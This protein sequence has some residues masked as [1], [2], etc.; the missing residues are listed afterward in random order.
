MGRMINIV[1]AM[2]TLPTEM[3]LEFVG[4]GVDTNILIL[5]EYV[6][7]SMVLDF[8]WGLLRGLWSGFCK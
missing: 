1:V 7:V 4:L 3:G 6:L 8:E 2:A 5:D